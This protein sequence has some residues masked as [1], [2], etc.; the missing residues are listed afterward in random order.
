MPSSI[1]NDFD[2]FLSIFNAINDAVFIHRVESGEIVSVNQAMCDLYG[3]DPSEVLELSLTDLSSGRFPNSERAALEWLSKTTQN[4]PQRFEW[5]AKKN[6]GNTFWVE[7]NASKV[8]IEGIDYYVVVVRDIDQQKTIMEQLR[9]SEEKFSAAFHSAAD[10]ISI[11]SVDTGVFLEVNESAEEVLGFPANELIGKS[12]L[13][14]GIWPIQSERERL[15][16]ILTETGFFRNE[17]AHLRKKSGKVIVTSISG[18]LLEID[19]EHYVLANIRDISRIVEANLRIEKLNKEL[20]QRIK[21]RTAQLEIANQELEAFSYSVSHDLR[22]PL[23]AIDGFA[24]IVIEEAGASLSPEVSGYLEKIQ[25]S[26]TKMD[27][28]IVGLLD[29]SRLERQK[30]EPT[31]V[32]LTF[33]ANQIYGELDEKRMDREILFTV[34]KDLLVFGDKVLLGILLTNLLENAI[35]FTKRNPNAEISIGSLKS[36]EGKVI[37]VSDNG[38]GFDQKFAHKIFEPFQR[39]HSERQFEG[40]GIGLAIARRIVNH[41]NGRIWVESKEGEGTTIFFSLNAMAA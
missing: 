27:N 30:Y 31:L 19:G 9:L 7:A 16:K 35:K 24:Q 4:S 5:L 37:F 29:L 23:R 10:L 2:S 12:A 28:L 26:S 25:D 13:D 8:R 40:I 22:A 18:N 3:Y 36:D 38:I 41:H 20:E 17:E 21:Q 14:L 15:T 32:N 6:D 34:E 33:L 11:S 39:L 1:F